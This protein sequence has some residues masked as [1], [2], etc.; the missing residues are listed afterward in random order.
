VSRSHAG[1]E[2]KPLTAYTDPTEYPTIDPGYL[3]HPADV[4]VLAAGLRMLDKVAKS[5]HL[6]DKF[7]K[8][9]FPAPEIDLQ[10]I[11]QSRQAV[12]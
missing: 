5:S 4:N 7:A 9:Q 12:R 10:D 1:L 3:R 11:E 2:D 8:R 6:K